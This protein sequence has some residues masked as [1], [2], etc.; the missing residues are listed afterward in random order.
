M[1]AAPVAPP[2]NLL[3]PE[4]YVEPFDAYRWLRDHSPVHWDPVQQ[5]WGV[6]RHADVIAVEKDPHRYSS[7]RGSRPHAE[8]GGQSM[9]NMDDPRH[10]AHR[11]LVNRRFTP[12]VV[13]EHEALVRRLATEI[14]DG[15]ADEGG[16]EVVEAI[17]SRLPAMAIGHLLG[18]PHEHWPLL[19]K[20]SEQTMYD[21][22]QTRAD[23]A[24]WEPSADS[25][26]VVMEFASVALPLLAERRADPRDDLLSIWA[27]AET[28]GR[29]WTDG[30]A[31]AEL[32]LVID[33]GAETTR[34]VIASMVR[35]L[36]LQPDQQDRLRAEPSLLSGPAVE[37]FIRWVSPISSMRRTVTADHDVQGQALHAGEEVVL[38]YGAANRDDR[39][40]DEPERFD[41]TR[42]HNQHVAFGWGTHFCL[43][44]ALARLELRV[45]FDELLRRLPRWRLTGPEP[46]IVPGTFARA[47]DAVQV[48]W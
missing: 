47:Y 48:E 16:C 18:F 24:P 40:F 29:A 13:R 17:A 27:H 6:S 39:V 36:A 43:G 42:E 7:A 14:I 35:E 15:V 1:T 20:V 3:D 10:L 31:H 5:V 37:E 12:R 25:G 9:I 33:G 44:A 23:G 32:L 4:F 21:A 34:T 26:E 22:G 19:R 2:V 28:D 30:E 11:M 41:V 45:I 46:R 8:Q 38:L